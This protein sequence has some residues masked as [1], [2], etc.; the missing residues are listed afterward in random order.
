MIAEVIAV[1]VT[2]LAIPTGFVAFYVWLLQSRKG[3]LP[4]T[5]TEC[6]YN[7]NKYG[8]ILDWDKHCL[9]IHKNPTLIFSGEFHYWRLP[10]QSRW[11]S[12]LK[13]YRAG[14]FNCIRIYFHWGFHNPD[15]GIYKF[16][17]NRDVNHLL[18]LCEKLGLYVLAAPGPYICAETQVG[19]FPLWL[20]AEKHR[21][22]HIKFTGFKE[23]DK[24][25][26]EYEKEWFENILPI[27]ARHQITEKSNG[28]VIALQI[29]NE[30][31]E[32]ARKIPFG[33]HDEMR[34]LCK[35]A[36]DCGITVPLFTNDP[37][38]SGS[39]IAKPEY[40]A[41]PSTNFFN[42]RSFGLDLY[43]FDKY[44]IFAPSD[45]PAPFDFCSEQDPKKWK[46]WDPKDMVNALDHL[47]KEVRSFGHD[48]AKSPIFI[49]ELQGGWYTSYKSKHTFD[50]IY[51]FYGDRFTRIVYDSVLAQGCTMLSFYMVYGGTNWGT[52]GDID[53]TTSYDYSA[54]IRE[55]GYISARLRNL[56]L[57][58]FFARSFSDVF[59]KTVRVKNPNIR[60]SIKNVFNLQRRAV[61]D[62]GEESNAVVFTF[63]R[64][65]SKTES[66][67]FELFVNYIGAQGKKVLFGM[68][69]YL[70]YKSS[71]IALG[72]YVTSTG[73][74]LIFSS[75][76][77]H[78]RILHPPSGSD[79]G[80]EIWI[81][82]VN[83]GGEFAFEGEINVDGNLRSSVRNIGDS[84]NIVSFNDGIG[85]ARIRHAE[86]SKELIILALD[87]D[88]LGTLHAVFDEPHWAQ[89]HNRAFNLSHS[90]LIVSW[91]TQNVYFD[92]ENNTIETEYG[93]V[94]KEITI[95]SLRQLSDH[96]R[97]D[98][99]SF[100]SLPFIYKK[101]L[102]K[103]SAVHT[104][105]ELF[106]WSTRI[107][108]FSDL[109]WREIDLKNGGAAENH[110]ASGHVLY[111]AKF[112]SMKKNRKIQL[113]VNMRHRCTIFVNGKFAGG[114]MT[115]SK[116]LFF[117]GVKMG[118]ELFA[119]LGDKKYDITKFVNVNEEDNIIIILVDNLGISRQSVVFNDARNP[120][121]LISAKISGLSKVKWEICGVDVRKL[122]IPFITSGF[123]DEHKNTG[124]IESSSISDYGVM[125]DEGV[126]WWSFKFKHPVDPKYKEIINSPLRLVLFG[127]FTSFIFLNDTLI[128]RYYG[129]GDFSQHNYYLMD[130]LLK[131][132]EENKI[133]LMIYSWEQV[134]SNDI[135][136]EVRGW[137]IDDVNKSG[138]IIEIPEDAND[139]HKSWVVMREKIKLN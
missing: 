102:N 137:E 63:L 42:R 123:P 93:E 127:A 116:N 1:T 37:D 54:C 43:G 97:V 105:P 95:L 109:E 64:N 48:A 115:F 11:E 92:L 86:D 119:S 41:K 16:D 103:P 9:Y 96:T 118:P 69:C 19:G 34:F 129:N 79:P 77:I 52:L 24:T 23:Y 36:R 111:R 53:G 14:G 88:S 133:T 21:I 76:P 89:A 30:L 20:A 110:Y 5:T 35:V 138:N 10:D 134:H 46:P 68:Q 18:N 126:K 84:I 62:S 139:D 57:G 2:A 124:W 104:T 67:K 45:S 66:P 27:L 94:E 58:L 120:R 72:N 25:F 65:F 108:N 121:G 26:A 70:P 13:K 61:V 3:T 15:Q 6:A 122:E 87:N 7:R 106:N 81:I 39:F 22:R 40:D 112:P 38:E 125:P 83:D 4:I 8:H 60:A 101:Q 82:P 113:N 136:V 130:G 28:C 132:N 90:P 44:F 74:K 50:D 51:N 131:F 80:R 29:E 55:S 56:R 75:I 49:P 59:A 33:L 12:V 114:H 32:K 91:G 85:F 100:Y 107:T 98:S 135:K 78:L 128:G 99:N 71:F 117:P 17:G 31:F 47:E 73:L